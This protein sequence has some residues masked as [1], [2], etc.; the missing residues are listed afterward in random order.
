[1][2]QTAPIAWR[3]VRPWK[4]GFSGE[5]PPTGTASRPSGIRMDG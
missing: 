1:M 5:M 3:F 4:T 2:D